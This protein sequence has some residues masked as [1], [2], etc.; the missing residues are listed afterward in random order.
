MGAGA[1]ARSAVDSAAFVAEL[2]EFSSFTPF[3]IHALGHFALA[4]TKANS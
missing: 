1:P 4:H 2:C 3:L